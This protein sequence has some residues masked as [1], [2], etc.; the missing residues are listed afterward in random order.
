MNHSPSFHTDTDLDKDIKESLLKDTFAMLNF[1]VLDRGMIER[2][3]RRRVQQRIN[4]M[5]TEAK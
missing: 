5:L 3:D 1:K 2:E 4:N